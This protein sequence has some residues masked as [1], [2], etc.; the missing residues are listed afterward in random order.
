MKQTPKY[1]AYSIKHNRIIEKVTLTSSNETFDWSMQGSEEITI[2]PLK[3]KEE[4]I[5]MKNTEHVDEEGTPIYEGYKLNKGEET[6][7]VSESENGFTLTDR[8]KKTQPFYPLCSKLKVVG[9]IH[10]TN[11]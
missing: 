4:F 5:L 11:I 2:N 8:N 1:K 6:F 7:I 3:C 9:N 10:E